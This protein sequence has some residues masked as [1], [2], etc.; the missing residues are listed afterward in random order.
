MEILQQQFN[1]VFAFTDSI[2]NKSKEIFLALWEFVGEFD[3]IIKQEEKK[4]PY[5]INLIDEL[6]AKENAH[7]RI[8]GKLLQQKSAESGHFKILESFL[9]FIKENHHIKE[10]FQ[11]LTVKKPIITQEFKRID[12]WI[13][14]TEYAIIIENKVNRALDRPNQLERYINKTKKQGFDEH[15]IYVL[16]LPPT[17]R[18]EPDEQAWGIYLEND[19]RKKRYLSLSFKDDILSWLKEKLL[20][21]IRSNDKF[22]TSTLEQYIDHLEGKFNIRITN[23]KMNM[24]LQ[25]FIR[26]K[27]NINDIEPEKAFKI[28]S[29]KA[30]VIKN[31]LLQLESLQE[32][33]Q[34]EI[35]E[36]FFSM[37]FTEL[38]ALNYNV[39]RVNQ[40]YPEYNDKSVSVRLANKTTV[41]I[42][43]DDRYFCQVNSTGDITS[44]PLRF[45]E[46]E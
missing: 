44:V 31:V 41:W 38:K 16:Y 18:E 25:K 22:L 17:Y 37:C 14:D 6:R 29:K 2:V 43:K 45:A 32:R 4:M 24:E 35:D 46:T 28:V 34:D 39:V 42:G 7:S 26:E 19:I 36:K 23:C 20:P 27:L 15:Q 11:S 8:L 3:K 21:S 40:D 1:D 33:I 30:Q 10:D 9:N 13:R 5:H 12:L